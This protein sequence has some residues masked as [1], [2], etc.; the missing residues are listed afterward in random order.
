MAFAAT[1]TGTGVNTTLT[2][3]SNAFT[4]GAADAG[5]LVGSDV[6]ATGLAAGTKVATISGTTGTLTNN[7]TGTTGTVSVLYGSK[8]GSILDVSLSASTDTATPQN[9]L[10]A[11]FGTALAG[12]TFPMI[13]FTGGLTVRWSNIVAGAIYDF[14]NW[15]L[16]FGVGGRWLFQESSI[17]GELRGGYLVNGT[18]FLKTAGPTFYCWNWNNNSAGGSSMFQNNDG[19]LTNI[20]LFRM[21]NPRFIELNGG[22]AAPVF[23]S[24]RMTMAVENMILDYQTDA[25]GANAGIGAAFGTLKNTYLIKTNAGIGATNGSNY[26]TFDGLY[27][28]GNYQSSPNHKFSMP[29]GYTLD[30]YAPQVLSTQ[31]LG[32]FNS[33]TSEIYSNINLSTAGWGL[34]DLPSK[35]QRYSGPITLQFPRTVSF[36]M[37]DSTAAALTNVTLYIKSGGTSLVNAVQTGDYSALTQGINLSWSTSQTVYRTAHNVIDTTQQIAQFRKNGYVQQTVSYDINTATYSQ[38]VFMLADPAYGSITTTAAAALTGITPNYGNQIV[39]VSSARNL[40]EVYAYGGYSL[41]L[42]ANS[43][44]SNYQTSSGGAYSLTSPWSMQVISGALT[45]GTYSKTINGT[46]QLRISGNTV[47]H[48]TSGALWGTSANFWNANE[49]WGVYRTYS[50]SGSLT[51]NKNDVVW[52]P[53]AYADQIFFANGATFNMSNNATLTINPTVNFGYLTPPMFGQYVT[54]NLADSTVTYNL[55]T[56]HAGNIFGADVNSTVGGAPSVTVNYSNFNLVVNGTS[57]NYADVQCFWTSSST[58]NNWNISGTAAA[59]V[60]LGVGFASQAMNGLTFAGG[61]LGSNLAANGRVMY[62]NNLTYTGS[63]S[64]LSGAQGGYPLWYFVDPV[65][66][67]SAVFRWAAGSTPTGTTGFNA[68][69]GFRPTITIDK[70]GYAPKMRITPSTLSSR[71]TPK[72]ITT[73]ALSNVALSNFYRDSVYMAGTDGFLPFVDSLDDK[74]VQNIIDWTVNFRAAGW[75]DQTTTFAG[76]TAKKGTIVYTAS[77]AADANYVNASTGLADSALIS[78][79]TTTKT[80]SSV[81]GTITWSP[82]RLYNALKNW[83]A[84]YASDT[85]FLAATSGGWLDLGD[86]NTNANIRFGVTATGDAL[87]NVRTTGLINATTND[88][89]VTD[90]RGTSTLFSFVNVLNGST[91][92]LADNTGAQRLLEINTSATTYNVYIEPG[93]SGNW[94]AKLRKY[95]YQSTDVIFTPPGGG[96]F[97]GSDNV[98]DTYVVDTLSNV[99]AYTDLETTQKVYD[100]SSYWMTTSDGITNSKPFAKGFGTLTANE[101]YTLD[102]VAAMMMTI[103]TGT[104]ITHTSGFAESVTIL[105]T[106]DFTQ[107]TATLS[108]SVQIRANN[109]DSELVYSGID[110]ITVYPTL[111]DAMAGTNA[112]ASSTNGILRFLYG[113]SLSG[114]TMSGTIY[115]R[116]QIGSVNEIQSVTL[117]QGHNVLDLSTTV[118]LQS[119]IN[120]VAQVPTAVLAAQVETGAT[121]AESLRLHNSVLGGKVSGGQTG[122]EHFRDLA[123]TKDRLLSSN[124]AQGNRTS[125]IYDLT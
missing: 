29:N 122:K 72:I 16:Y 6:V 18:Q 60:R 71:Y 80:I 51:F 7:F 105:V 85:D 52:T 68:V 41:A 70:T 74:T 84:T 108:N 15:G 78:V 106:G 109:L 1:L 44:Y 61:F 34:R 107:G 90:S 50:T 20:G 67:D 10:N 58:I 75:I 4:L 36:Q 125:E 102:P 28:V 119:I 11:G 57:V 64:P 13:Q 30:G 92:Y 114:V 8:Y 82:Q 17:L 39:E 113:A 45:M 42:P 33:A 37:K 22:N 100:Y 19:L 14:A 83:W 104:A 121:V 95:G 23:S 93:A 47:A 94:S 5:I 54:S 38:P 115:L 65:R 73:T 97:I 55:N 66:S 49:T 26:A 87:T 48:C 118:L 59:S 98:V 3:G 99:V 9:I 101:P 62:M 116:T 32:G 79:N 63:T 24:A 103:T 46:K 77:G 31:L 25:N 27:Y 43:A 40:D 89:A 69:L 124:D 111:N 88:I 12:G 123:D 35:Y 120:Q 56:G 2:N 76:A 81:S 86:Y 53:A 96:Y 21:H 110:N 117:V 112:G 91:V